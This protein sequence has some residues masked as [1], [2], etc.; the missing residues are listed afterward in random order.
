MNRRR[1]S[2]RKASTPL[3]SATRLEG[4]DLTEL[5]VDT[6]ARHVKREHAGSG[7]PLQPDW[8]KSRA[9][10]T[11]ARLCS[12]GK[13]PPYSMEGTVQRLADAW[14]IGPNPAM[15]RPAPPGRPGCRTLEQ[16]KGRSS[17]LACNALPRRRWS[18]ANFRRDHRSRT[19]LVRPHN[20]LLSPVQGLATSTH[21]SRNRVTP[22]A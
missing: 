4:R 18:W 15:R 17:L 14:R 7:L 1:A 22:V 11:F 3:I 19:R 2:R 21:F 20:Y 5:R 10:S 13:P 16:T 8:H 9:K 12:M 6:L